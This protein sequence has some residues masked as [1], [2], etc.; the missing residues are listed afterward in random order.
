[1]LLLSSAVKCSIIPKW[2]VYLIPPSTDVLELQTV[3]HFVAFPSGF[4]TLK[5]R[6]RFELFP[7]L[8]AKFPLF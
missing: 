1:M 4:L 8:D 7:A 6:V 5:I 3:S 2:A